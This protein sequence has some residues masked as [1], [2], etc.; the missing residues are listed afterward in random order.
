MNDFISIVDE[1][2]CP[3][4][5][6]YLTR[7]PPNRYT[8][9]TSVTDI[10][11]CINSYFESS[12]LEQVRKCDYFLQMNRQMKPTNRTQFAIL[13]R[14]LVNCCVDDHLLGIINVSCTHAATLMGEIERFLLAKGVDISKAMFVGFDGCNTVSGEN[15]GT[16]NSIIFTVL[17]CI[18]NHFKSIKVNLSTESLYIFFS[19]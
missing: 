19:A 9:S 7:N 8:S 16:Y 4:V 12:L 14:C 18:Y 2:K 5:T 3:S 15:K 17:K 1:L 13:I 10:L 6:Q 11:D